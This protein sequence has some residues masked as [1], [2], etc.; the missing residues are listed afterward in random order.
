MKRV[1]PSFHVLCESHLEGPISDCVDTFFALSC[2]AKKF[3]FD[4]TSQF[5]TCNLGDTERF[6]VKF[7]KRNDFD[8][9]GLLTLNKNQSQRSV[10]SQ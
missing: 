4:G 2:V 8:L 5:P 7:F 10:P 3:L 6:V 9:L 1:Y